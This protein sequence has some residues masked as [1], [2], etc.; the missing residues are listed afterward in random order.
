MRRLPLY[1]TLALLANFALVLWHLEALGA[2]HPEMARAPL[3]LLGGGVAAV[4]L[5]LAALL[6]SRGRGLAAWMLA[7]FFAATASIGLYE[8]FLK[9]GPDNVLTMVG[10]PAS[11][12]FQASATLLVLVEA[13]GCAIALRGIAAR[14]AR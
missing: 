7:V 9:P 1:G 10:G 14:A 6:W 2:R 4:S 13:L 11:P 5:V 3:L 12:P 8:H